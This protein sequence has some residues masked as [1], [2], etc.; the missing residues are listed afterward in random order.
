MTPLKPWSFPNTEEA[1]K[2]VRQDPD[3]VRRVLSLFLLTAQMNGSLSK[4]DSSAIADAAEHGRY[5]I[6]PSEDGGTEG[7]DL[8]FF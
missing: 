4:A 2:V 3:G 5:K 6:E 8:I 1:E 7:F